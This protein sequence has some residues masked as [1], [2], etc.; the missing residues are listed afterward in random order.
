MAVKRYLGPEASVLLRV[1]GN[2]IGLV[3]QGEAIFVPDEL[4]ELTVWQDF[5]EDV[6][7]TGDKSDKAG[8]GDK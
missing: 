4:A 8:K 1:A 2:E 3:E 7:S 6:K 5:W